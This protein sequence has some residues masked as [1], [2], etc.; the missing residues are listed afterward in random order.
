MVFYVVEHGIWATVLFKT[1]LL[2]YNIF[3]FI[4]L[5]NIKIYKY[6]FLVSTHTNK[7]RPPSTQAKN[8]DKGAN[9]ILS[10]LNTHFFHT[11]H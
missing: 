2:Y 5:L 11:R 10:L 7:Y 6:E 4:K 8:T 9:M 3:N 1:F